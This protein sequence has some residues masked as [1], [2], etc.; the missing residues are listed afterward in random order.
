MKPPADADRA[1]VATPAF[2]LPAE[3]TPAPTGF[4]RQLLRAAAMG[5]A[6]LSLVWGIALVS[7]LLAAIAG[8][9]L[10]VPIGAR[11][12]RSRLR[13][14][15]AL[16]AVASAF[17]L[18]QAVAAFVVGAEA[19]P[20]A[21]GVGAALA[22]AAAIRFGSTAFLA[23]ATLRTLAARK[24]AAAALEILVLAAAIPTVF[25]SHRDGVI[26]RPLWLSDLAWQEGID[27]THIFLGIGAASVAVL[28]VLLLAENRSGRAPSSF[29]A[30]AA[31]TLLAL[32]LFPLLGMPTPSPPS[33]LGLTSSPDGGSP[34][35]KDPGDAGRGERPEDS[36][37]GDPLDG[38]AALDGAALIAEGGVADGSA[39]PAPVSSAQPSDGGTPVAPS[40][41]LN[42]DSSNSSS[43][44][45]EA[46]MAVVILDDDYSPPSQGFYF[47]QGVWSQWNG[48]RLVG[49]SRSDVDRDVAETFPTGDV[50]VLDPPPEAGRERV[51][52]KVVLLVEHAQ[53]FALES[54][55][56]FAPAPNPN[57]SRFVRAYRT[58]SLAQGQPYRE[59]FGRKAGN[60]AWSSAVRSFYLTGSADP[61]YAELARD[62]EA[63]VP[64]GR[65]GDPFAAALTVKLYLDDQFTYSTRHRHA[66]AADPTADFLFGDRTGYCVHFA[67]AAVLLWRALGIPARV[68]T[69]YRAD[70]TDRHGSSTI[71]I[72]SADAHAWPELYLE[73]AGWIVLD[74]AAKNTLDPTPPPVD[75]D[76]QRLL[77]E[78]ARKMP[79]NPARTA[80][81]E[82]GGLRLGKY[83]RDV[84]LFL[85]F[86]AAFLLL[87]LYATKIWRRLAPWVS[88]PARLPFSGY[89]AT[90]DMLAEV[91]QSRRFGETREAFARRVLELTPSFEA[92][93]ALHVAAALGDGSKAIEA[94]EEF[95]R[96]RWRAGLRAVRAE[97]Q[98][99]AKGWR[100]VVGAL[101]PVSFLRSR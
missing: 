17:G 74:I 11:L 82:G 39:P 77:G 1:K 98:R 7:G 34:R 8:A 37:G 88:G 41:H 62:L 51:H 101:D 46:P 31:L 33:E 4:F 96:A 71:L 87:F 22:A 65:K 63:R 64:P 80:L 25:A 24:P 79:P 73:G 19:V 45:G 95:S 56:R 97:I 5:M 58:E 49:A 92:L 26:A 16:G 94:R 54:A 18:A 32:L 36:D 57:P 53:P 90:L 55:V 50:A 52:A 83:G 100:R 99:G 69:G 75:S 84:G 9:A 66:G 6:A 81:E 85:L 70:E 15:V 61:R 12:G 78:M 48:A 2:F 35:P 42:D 76:L 91:G 68:G 27:P 23:S 20:G 28:A 89:R 10:G 47:R 30:L 43:S 21:I 29:L 13:L 40:E 14:P 60:P 93:T 67:H 38:G 86:L 59:L 44:G 3:D 72:R